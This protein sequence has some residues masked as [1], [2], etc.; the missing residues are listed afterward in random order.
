MNSTSAIFET[1]RLVIRRLKADD[2]MDLYAICSDREI[3]KYVGDG[4]PLTLDQV[5]K[6]LLVTETNYNTKGFGNYA[7]VCKSSDLLIGYCGLV[8]SR[9]IEKTELIYAFDKQHWHLG[10]ATEASKG[11]VAFGLDSLQL[12][13]IYASID[14]ENYSSEK[15]LKK[16]G[17]SY[18]FSRKDEF[19]Y[20]TQYYKIS[21]DGP[22]T[23]DRL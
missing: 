7:V 3:M 22:Y 15:I 16:I 13:E 20:P 5:N 23:N 2:L 12:G 19:G 21:Q 11:M 17:F 1:P 8:Y 9:Q 14:P 4:E 18:V 10:L 6:W